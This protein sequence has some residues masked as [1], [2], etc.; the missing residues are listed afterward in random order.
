MRTK[1]L[2]S[3]LLITLLTTTLFAQDL[4]QM[5]TPPQTP[6]RQQF[7]SQL[8][9]YRDN[10][11]KLRAIKEQYQ[12]ANPQEKDAL[13]EQFDPL[14]AETEIMQSHLIPLA[15]AAYQKVPENESDPEIMLFLAGMLQWMTVTRENYET[16]YQIS[17]A[18]LQ[19]EVPEN[20]NILYAYAA[21][22]AFNIMELDNAEK[23]FKIAAEK[24]VIK[25]VDPQNKMNIEMVGYQLP[26]YKKLWEEEKLI[27]EKQAT[28][29]LPLVSLH[30][31]KGD[32]VIELFKE[33]APN[34]VG[35][36]LTLVSQGFY[37]D[38]PFHRVLPYFMAQGGDPTGTGS[39]GPGYC[40]PCECGQEN[41]RHHFRGSLSMAHAGP[42]TGGSQFFLT[43]VPTGFLDGKHTVFGR[44]V[45]GMNILS[46]IQRIDPEDENLPSPDKILEAK[47]IRGEPFEFEKLRAR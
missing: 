29:N 21:Y 20:M 5:P 22:A 17:E 41:A 43:F 7:D 35:N 1:I 13:K 32:I 14:I 19:K 26:Q 18:F 3:I 36:F 42:D 24:D 47:I 38:V 44:V 2:I 10:L 15:V 11:K 12:T 31:T 46:D 8:S 25:Q 40:I 34:A 27:R 33:E 39:G 30:T 9:A 4:Q 28:E 6:E 37:T 16:A 45:E 23:W